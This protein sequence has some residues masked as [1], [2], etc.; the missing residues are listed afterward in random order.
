MYTIQTALGIYEK[1]AWTG[2]DVP[3]KR[4]MDA[5]QLAE[6]EALKAAYLQEQIAECGGLAARQA[7]LCEIRKS[8]R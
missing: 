3:D 2:G 6:F 1:F 7:G 4:T 8:A 5:A